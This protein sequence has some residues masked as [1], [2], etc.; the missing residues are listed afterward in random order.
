M[1]V[2]KSLSTPPLFEESLKQLDMPHEYKPI[3]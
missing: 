1:S 2:V 3:K